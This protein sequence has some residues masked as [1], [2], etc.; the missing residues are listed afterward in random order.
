MFKLHKQ[1]SQL[2]NELSEDQLK[3]VIKAS[4]LNP[5][6]YFVPNGAQEKLIIAIA[7]STK[8]SR[9]PVILSTYANGVGK[10]TGVIHT[11]LNIIYKPQN[12]WFDF[13]L[14]HNYPFPKTI[15]YSSTVEAI[16][17]TI[18]PMIEALA[19][20]G[21]YR[22][23]K[24]GKSYVSK[25]IFQWKGATWNLSFK[26]FD[27][28]VKQYESATIGLNIVDEP[29]PEE[30]W[31]AVK[32]RRRLGCVSI[33]PMTPLYCPP[34]VLDE[35][36]AR[37][38]AKVGGYYHLKADVYSAC[39]ERGIRG[40]L[41]ADIIDRMVD[42]YDEEEKQARAFGEFMYF[43]GSI[44]P[45]LSREEHFVEPSK[46]PIP[47]YS[48]IMEVKDPHDGRPSAIIWG[49]KAPNGRIIIFD[50]LPER[51]DMS[52]W[53]MT[54]PIVAKDEIKMIWDK[55][56]EMEQNEIKVHRRILDKRFGWQKQAGTTLAKLYMQAGNELAREYPMYSNKHHVYVSSYNA[57]A[58]EGEIAFGHLQI[59][60]ALKPMTDGLPGLVIWN[61]CY[62]TW[63]GLT[64]YIKQKR[65]GKSADQFA[66]GDGK[67]VEK[68]KDFPD[69]VRY[70][71]C[72]GI[73]DAEIPEAR[74]TQHQK[75]A[76]FIKNMGRFPRYTHS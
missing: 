62:H 57:P 43:S 16:K 68:F 66:I 10:T 49:A 33:L 23:V 54:T 50:E 35:I 51:Q 52:F 13:P 12:G 67:I 65:T 32:A 72:A 34:Y 60:N 55:E 59:R 37:A 3:S 11:M 56:R 8:N 41:E 42:E 2:A 25:I 75:D 45:E 76:E 36:Q 24:E 19:K 15:W 40:H 71:I 1:I 26:T 22:F 73:G 47:I 29:M 30:L 69:A 6:K 9:V 48:H 17:D 7:N 27:Q 28:D 20:P 44:F 70:L 18:V 14:F 4:L 63:N 39:K 38:E 31:K 5:L 64:H 58:G 61:N 21:T 74:K 46:F 53:K